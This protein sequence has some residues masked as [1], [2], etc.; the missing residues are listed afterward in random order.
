MQ[1][2]KQLYKIYSRN[3]FNIL[4]SKREYKDKKKNII[5]IY[6]ICIILIA[7]ITY[8]I[9]YKS[10]DPIFRTLCEDK[11]NEIATII[12]NEESTNA[13]KNYKYGDMFTLEKDTNR[14]YKN[15]KCQYINNK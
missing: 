11:A 6:F 15:D 5:S 8:E 9:L 2:N 1:E 14:K 12:A 10:V 7:I 13:M 3:R 4:K